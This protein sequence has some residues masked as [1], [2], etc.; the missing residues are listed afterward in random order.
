V[1]TGI[2]IPT[3]GFA[4]GAGP[5]I[6][7]QWTGAART[8]RTTLILFFAA[9]LAA[10]WFVHSMLRLDPLAPIL[11]IAG[12]LTLFTTNLLRFDFRG[13]L[14]QMDVLK[15]L[16]VRPA[17]VVIGEVA[18]PVT[19]LSI[20]HFLLLIGL[21][22]IAP[23]D[24]II[25]ACAAL[26]VIPINLLFALLEN[27]I[28]LLFPVR[29]MTVSPGDL[30]GTGRRMVVL[31]IKLLGVSIAGVCAFVVGYF[32]CLFSGGSLLIGSAAA[33][34]TLC[35]LGILMVPL[36]GRAFQRFD[37]SVDTPV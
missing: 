5:L 35:G 25:A 26:L 6:W 11:T 37:P 27:Y 30:Q 14:E 36:L 13:D 10:A 33:A 2:Q 21:C 16:P 8:A 32:A 24:R 3:I 4:G 18:A 19:I 22:I 9:T 23:K 20:M 29:E 12:W 28:F 34:L 15:S 31:V 17:A 1:A 7:R